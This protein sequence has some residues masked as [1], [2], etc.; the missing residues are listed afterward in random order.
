MSSISNET[1]GGLSFPR[2]D[3]ANIERVERIANMRFI[4]TR[5]SMVMEFAK[6]IADLQRRA[7]MEYYKP[8]LKDYEPKEHENDSASWLLDQVYSLKQ[9][10]QRL[11]IAK[12]VYAEAKKIYDF[13]NSGKD[14]YT[15]RDGKIVKVEA[16]SYIRKVHN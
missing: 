7:D 16:G 15:M 9:M 11:G 6:E 13:S 2:P 4:V 8:H 12:R 5:K 14:G 3:Y 10:C 1:V